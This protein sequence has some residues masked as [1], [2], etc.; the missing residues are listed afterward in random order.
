MRTFH[1]EYFSAEEITD[2]TYGVRHPV[3]AVISIDGHLFEASEPADWRQCLILAARGVSLTS[4]PGAAPAPAWIE[5]SRRFAR[6]VSCSCGRHQLDPD[7][8]GF[9]CLL[10]DDCYQRASWENAHSDCGHDDGNRDPDCPVCQEE[11]A[12]DTIEGRP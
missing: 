3:T 10:C 9:D 11:A 4:P 2:P 7:G 6:M 5:A 8:E 1:D 12:A